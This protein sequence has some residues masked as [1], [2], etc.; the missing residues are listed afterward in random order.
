MG[1][2]VNVSPYL[3]QDLDGQGNVN[4]SITIPYDD[5]VTGGNTR[6]IT[7]NATIFRSATSTRTKAVIGDPTN[8]DHVISIPA[9][10]HTVTVATMAGLGITNLDQITGTQI[11]FA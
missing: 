4:I 8:P 9:G 1:F 10:T 2:G 11:T 5:G 3:D 7:G 6:A